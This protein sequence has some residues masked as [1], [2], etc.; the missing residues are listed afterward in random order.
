M[1]ERRM[2]MVGYRL[3][4]GGLRYIWRKNHFD[5]FTEAC[6][7]VDTPRARIMLQAVESV[8]GGRLH[9][10]AQALRCSGC[11][12]HTRDERHNLQIPEKEPIQ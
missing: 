8:N 5:A 12:E 3:P 6:K 10:F 7:G 4:D 9:E 1:K 11:E 2:N